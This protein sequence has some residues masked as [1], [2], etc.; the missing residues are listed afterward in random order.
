LAGGTDVLVIGGGIVGAATAYHLAR[1]G[2]DVTLLEADRLASGASGRN[3]GFIWQHTRRR[4]PELDLVAATR[5]EL[6]G[7][8]AELDADFG[9]RCAGGLVYI[10]REEQLPALREFVASRVA[11]GLDVRLLDGDEARDMAP[12]LSGRVLAASFCADDA[13][14][15][16]G[17]YVRA[18]A[19]AAEREGASV[20]EGVAARRLV[21]RN[22]RIEGVDTAAGLRPA[23]TVVLATG[24]WT[25][26]LAAEVGANLPIHPMRLQIVAT[27]AMPRRLEPLLYGPAAMKQYSIFQELPSFDA[28]D[29][30]VE[31]ETRHGTTLLESA[32]QRDDGSYLLGCAMD[33]PG[34]DWSPDVR[35]VAC[36]TEGLGA[37]L[38]ALAGARFASAWAGVLPYT[39]DNLPLI[40]PVPDVDG[41][42][43]A[44]GHVFGNGAGPTTGRL[45]ADLICGE[46]PAI[47]PAPFRP[48]RPGLRATGDASVW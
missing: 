42:F 28:A 31:A 12:I 39:S 43:V 15:D 8:P 18:F 36:I 7:L 1:R 14:I 48:D 22:G 13:Q 45:L 9:L 32:C 46:S 27:E 30:T 10:D 40:G 16:P 17:R 2:L 37:A 34:L 35:G 41:L 33:Y 20:E 29:F 5:R 23:G 21:A 25:P 19:H 4:G 47:D 26:P 3:L 6:E 24:A 11:D 38:P 44:A